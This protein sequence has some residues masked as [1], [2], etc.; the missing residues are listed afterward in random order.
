MDLILLNPPFHL[1]ASIHM[2]AA[3][4][5]FEAAARML[6]P[7][8]ELLTVYNSVL[9]YRPELTRVIG[10]TQ[11]VHRTSKFTVTRSVRR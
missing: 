7:G 1:G 2:G 3:T 4:R 6:K 9:G 11:Q 5:L 10:H 8:G